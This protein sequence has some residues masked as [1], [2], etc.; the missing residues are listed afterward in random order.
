MDLKGA[1]KA[2]EEEQVCVKRQ[3]TVEVILSIQ[4]A[5]NSSALKANVS[6]Q[7]PGLGGFYW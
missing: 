7:V 4:E 5:F 1:E 3:R 6:S 2:G